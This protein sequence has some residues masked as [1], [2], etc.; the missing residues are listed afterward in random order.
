MGANRSGSLARYLSRDR[1][2]P[3]I[4]WALNS[5][6][7]LDA[8]RL[9]LSIVAMVERVSAYATAFRPDKSRDREDK[10]SYSVKTADEL[11]RRLHEPRQAPYVLR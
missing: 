1:E 5:L 10:L 9:D 4:Q 8:D 6:S 11:A 2:S 3:L 7:A